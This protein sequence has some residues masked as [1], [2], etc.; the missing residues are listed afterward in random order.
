MQVGLGFTVFLIFFKFII[1]NET[2]RKY[3]QKLVKS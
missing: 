1:Y 3:F 2:L